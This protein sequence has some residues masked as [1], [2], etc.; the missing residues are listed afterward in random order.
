MHFQWSR[1]P[2]QRPVKRIDPPGSV[3]CI[4]DLHLGDGTRSD[5]FLGKDRTLLRFLAQVRE[6][7]ATLVVAGDAIDFSQAWGFERILKA[8][9]KVFA[10]LSGLADAGQ[11]V[12]VYGNHDHDIRFFSDI[13]RFPVVAELQVG[14]ELRILH[15]HE[16]DPYI[17]PNLE[18][19]ELQV[20]VHHLVERMLATWI[21]TPLELYYTRCNRVA[22]WLVHKAALL[23][24]ARGLILRQLGFPRDLERTRAQ[25]R[26]WTRTQLGDPGCLFEPAMAALRSGS[27]RTLVCGHSHLPGVVR[28]PDGRCYVNTGSWT[29]TSSTFM[30]WT[31][32]TGP[33]VRDFETGRAFD[34]RLYLPLLDG[35]FDH[36]SFFDWWRENY[37]GLLRYRCAEERARRLIP[38]WTRPPAEEPAA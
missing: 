8:H 28:L 34:E 14:H 4:S 9:G 11:L 2:E 7:G 26:Y 15:G 24:T 22:F 10:A 12:Y 27:H 1:P 20:R 33:E 31:A 13:L 3:Y 19:T 23:R 16:L 35:A 36:K 18:A 25:L 17:G 21:R 32:A 5:I 38:T 29:F 30:R 6:E 37:M